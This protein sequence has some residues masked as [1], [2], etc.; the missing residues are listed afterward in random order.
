MTY[1]DD[2]FGARGYLA[3]GKPDYAPRRGQLNMV[4]LVDKA[5]TSRGSVVVEAGTGVG[6]SFSYL[7][8]AIYRAVHDKRKTL[9]VT[10]NKKLQRQLIEKD[11][12]TLRKILPWSFS[13]GLAMG[14]GNYLCNYNYVEGWKTLPPDLRRWGEVT[15]KGELSELDGSQLREARKHQLALV[16]HEDCHGSS[17]C[18][19]PKGTVDAE[20]HR[21]E[22]L[23]NLLETHGDDKQE[24]NDFGIHVS[25]TCFARNAR[26]ELANNDVVV[27]NY[28]MLLIH[29][30]VLQLTEGFVYILP[31]FSALICDEAHNIADIAREMLGDQVTFNGLWTLNDAPTYR[32]T[33]QRLQSYLATLRE[34]TSRNENL[35]L[36]DALE[37]PVIEE[38]IKHLERFSEMKVA[39]SD[40]KGGRRK[41]R[42]QSALYKFK[43]L[44]T[45]EHDDYQVRYI[46][47]DLRL[48]RKFIDVRRFLSSIW[49]A[50]EDGQATTPP[51][52]VV[53]TSAT[54][55]VNNSF[56]YLTSE[57][58]IGNEDDRPETVF[59]T[60]E[61]PFQYAKNSLFYIDKK[62][63]DPGDDREAWE[64]E[65]PFRLRELLVRNGGR[66]ICLFTSRNVMDK[67]ATKFRI[68]SGQMP[69]NLLVQG[70]DSSQNQRL[71]EEFLKDKTSVLFGLASFREGADAPGDTCTMVV[72]DKIPFPTPTDPLMQAIAQRDERWFGHHA[73]PRAAIDLKQG[74]G[75]LIRSVNDRGVIVCLDPR[76]VTRRYGRA[77]LNSRPAEMPVTVHD[78]D[79]FAAIDR[80]RGAK[81]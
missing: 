23:S 64:H 14:K 47:P 12:P 35:W 71:F 73:I 46:D 7:V 32:N 6:K 13:F 59:A 68:A 43:S 54:L 41:R 45:D 16:S 29:F 8:P 10:S 69:F 77:I 58:G 63:P 40:M 70:P 61:S 55:T 76:I 44:V 26:L 25:S 51:V 34:G 11:L 27:A 67:T 57:V 52:T 18:F 31:P 17:C 36:R 20:E 75:R 49:N 28:H 81:S 56:D 1:I 80:F 19:I 3:Q 24:N 60:V 2:V 42:V 5:Y 53:M 38:L 22:V 4:A 74:I 66:A 72:I 65:L 9:V 21:R 33:V 30:M 78:R 39:P 48:G 62:M 37:H 79:L 50:T 15:Y